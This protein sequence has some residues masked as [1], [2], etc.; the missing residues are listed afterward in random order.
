MNNG[1][2]PNTVQVLLMTD[3]ESDDAT[4]NRTEQSRRNVRVIHVLLSVIKRYAYIT[5]EITPLTKL[6]LCL[7]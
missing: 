3:N 2:N 1:L 4:Q 5:F 7:R 6:L